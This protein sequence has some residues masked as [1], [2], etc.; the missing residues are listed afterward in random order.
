MQI[1]HRSLKLIISMESPSLNLTEFEIK[2]TLGVGTFGRVRLALKKST[3]E[4]FAIKI[5]K[6]SEIIRLRQIDHIHNEFII[7]KKLHHPFIVNFYGMAQDNRNLFM[8]LELGQGGELFT[9]LRGV[10]R[11]EANHGMVYAA[12]VISIF[13]YMH[14]LN[15]VY[16]DLKPEN[17]LIANDGYLKLTDFGFAK[18]VT[19]RTYTLCGTPGYLAPE[20][21]L[22]KGHGKPV[23]WWTFGILL[24]E[25]LAGMDP[26]SDDDPMNIYQKILKGRVKFPRSFN[27]NAKSLVKHLLVANLSKRYGNL[28][29]GVNDIKQ[30]RFF[31]GLD[32]QRLISKDIPMPYVPIIR[33]VGD[34]SHFGGY[35]DSPSMPSRVQPIDDPFLR[36]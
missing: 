31:A 6:K 11:L 35:P 18:E 30:H 20:I 13:E 32:W 9:Y 26:F 33:D 34:C 28:K 4:F 24:Y 15:V 10:G 36:W 17:I 16:R 25:M 3:G 14:D 22:N 29:N 2:H 5:L 8:C 21:L 23:D 12:Q 1:K 27:A 19:G 7:L